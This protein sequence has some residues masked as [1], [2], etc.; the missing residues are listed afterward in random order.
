M[1]KISTYLQQS[2]IFNTWQYKLLH[3]QRL[4][5]VFC[6]YRVFQ[7][8]FLIFFTFMKYNFDYKKVT[9]KSNLIVPWY[10]RL[11]ITSIIFLCN[12]LYNVC[13]HSVPRQNKMTFWKWRKCHMFIP[14]ISKQISPKTSLTQDSIFWKEIYM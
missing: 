2:D 14:I 6:L 7:Y 3:K 13:E 9:L 11:C 10:G 8:Y 5:R 12:T 1:S 4:Y